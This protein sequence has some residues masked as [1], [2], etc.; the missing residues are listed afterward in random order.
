M[1]RRVLF[2]FIKKF[3]YLFRV[4]TKVPDEVISKLSL[5]IRRSFIS[6][7]HL[8]FETTN[9]FPSKVYSQENVTGSDVV[10][11]AFEAVITTVTVSFAWLKV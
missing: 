4:N 6:L 9:T 3:F 1:L 5:L 10:P 2:F 11:S 8:L 7:C